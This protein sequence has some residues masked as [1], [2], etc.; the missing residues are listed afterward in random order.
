MQRYIRYIVLGFASYIDAFF[1]IWCMLS[2]HLNGLCDSL[3]KIFVYADA[4]TG[5]KNCAD[6]AGNLFDLFHRSSYFVYAGSSIAQ[7]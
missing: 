3:I 7:R 1:C 6:D 2:F 5:Q 4:H